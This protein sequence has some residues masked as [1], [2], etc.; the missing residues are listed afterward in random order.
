[1]HLLVVKVDSCY[2][3][4]LVFVLSGVR[5]FVGPKHPEQATFSKLLEVGVGLE[6]WSWSWTLDMLGPALDTRGLGLG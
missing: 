3:L 5:T 6:T 1:M 4:T 2:V